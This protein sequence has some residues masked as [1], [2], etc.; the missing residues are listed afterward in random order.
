MV[1]AEASE[2]NSQHIIALAPWLNKMRDQHFYDERFLVEWVAQ[3]IHEENVQALVASGGSIGEWLH[4]NRYF[5]SV[6]CSREVDISSLHDVRVSLEEGR[7]DLD[8]D[9][10]PCGEGT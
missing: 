6:A 5:R 10:L 8:M 7:T 2:R 1:E 4:R 3:R 9:N